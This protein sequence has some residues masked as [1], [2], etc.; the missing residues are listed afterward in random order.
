MERVFSAIFSTSFFVSTL[1]LTTPILLAA[2]GAI[3]TDRAG[4]LNLNL[5]G[6]M[7]AAALGGVLGSAWTG[8][9][10]VGILSAILIGMIIA[11]VLAYVGIYLKSNLVLAGTALNL[12]VTGATIFVL[13]IVTG[14][15]GTS[16]ALKSGKIPKLNIPFIKDIPVV[17]KLLSGHS[18]MTYFAFLC[19]FIA[20]YLIYR[21]AIGLRIRAVGEN[22]DAAESVG[23][24]VKT[25]K[26]AS[27]LICGFFAALGGSFLSMY[28]V[29]WFQRDMTAGRG[30]IALAAMNLGNSTPVGTM[31]AA[32]LF[33]ASEQLGNVLQVMKVPP[34]IVLMI[35]YFVTLVG[36]VLY[37]IR[38][39]SKIKKL[40]ANN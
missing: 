37:A 27:L 8:S 18:V 34:Q 1:K 25:I 29:S 24:N 26:T 38:R 10:F 39:E 19:V 13:F 4:V 16:T 9:V 5:E 30:F 2:L 12:F 36:L 7:L 15:K 20:S 33:G 35:P 6:V 28:Y 40:K 11:A 23:I 31:L 17:G 3:F 14:E 22:P 21:T 32:L